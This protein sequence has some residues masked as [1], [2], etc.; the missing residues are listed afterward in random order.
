MNDNRRRA[1]LLFLVLAAF[2][3]NAAFGADMR[4]WHARP[5]IAVTGMLVAAQF[6]GP[7]TG[8]ALGF[9]A[10]LLEASY[11]ASFVGSFLFT[12]TLAG[13]AVGALEQRIYR[14]NVLVTVG[15][16]AI[17]TL[18]IQATFYLVAPQHHLERYL[19][20]SAGQAAYNSVIAI[21]LF[22][23]FRH[24]VGRKRRALARA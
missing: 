18:F 17:G 4:A 12:R 2:V 13:Y 5:D 15:I 9:L 10:G 3:L 8:A 22:Y 20:R 21:P 11:T 19:T 7:N 24:L 23:L 14:E 1:K 16:V 6:S